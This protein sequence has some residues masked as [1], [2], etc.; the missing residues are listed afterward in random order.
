VH[1]RDIGRRSF[2]PAPILQVG[3]RDFAEAIFENIIHTNL[4]VRFL[5]SIQGFLC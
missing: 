3:Q 5:P 1:I 2:V 4:M